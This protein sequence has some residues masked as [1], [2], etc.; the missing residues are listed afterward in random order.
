MVSVFSSK[1]NIVSI[2]VIQ[3]GSGFFANIYN[4]FWFVVPR[5]T[6]LEDFD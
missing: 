2:N 6:E 1:L 3:Q 5:F 4:Y